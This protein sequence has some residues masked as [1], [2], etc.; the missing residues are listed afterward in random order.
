[1][2]SNTKHEVE[3]EE[4]AVTHNAAGGVHCA[5]TGSAHARVDDTWWVGMKTR[6]LSGAV[7]KRGIETGGQQR[8]GEGRG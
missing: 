4:L 2:H 3:S 6:R 1:M 7:G 5:L 8:V